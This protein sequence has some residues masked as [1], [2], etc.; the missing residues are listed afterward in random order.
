MQIPSVIMQKSGT[1]HR[2]LQICGIMMRQIW[3]PNTAP[4]YRNPRVDKQ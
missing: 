3:P 2:L 4:M 1:S